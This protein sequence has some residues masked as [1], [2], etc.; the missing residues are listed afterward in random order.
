MD[1]PNI[2]SG[3]SITIDDRTED[4]FTP[5]EYD[6]VDEQGEMFFVHKTTH[7]RVSFNTDFSSFTTISHS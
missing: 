2:P 3:V 1:K 6:K 4:V 7:E 5:F